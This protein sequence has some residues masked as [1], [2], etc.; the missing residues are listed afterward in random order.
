ESPWR[1]SDRTA[2][3]DHEKAPPGGGAKGQWY[4]YDS[5]ALIFPS[6]KPPRPPRPPPRPR[7]APTR[8]P[9]P[10]SRAGHGGC[11]SNPWAHSRRAGTAAD[12][13]WPRARG[14]TGTALRA[15]AA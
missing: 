12:T 15:R 10:R 8:P 11:A 3:G 7:A 13:R 5:T 1:Q 6:V 9:Q 2:A 14:A 4:A